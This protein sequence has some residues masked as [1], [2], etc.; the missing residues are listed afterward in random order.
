MKPYFF[1]IMLLI[2]AIVKLAVTLVGSDGCGGN[3][4]NKR[5]S[6]SGIL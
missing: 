1:K 3:L 6:S 2:S 5:F 4:G